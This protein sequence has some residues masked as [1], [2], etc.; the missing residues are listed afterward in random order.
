MAVENIW[1]YYLSSDRLTIDQSFG[2]TA[3]SISCILGDVLI[4]GFD[5]VAGIP[6][7][8]IYLAENQTVTVSAFSGINILQ[9]D[10]DATGGECNIIGKQ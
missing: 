1:T 10:I 4:T 8:P 6:S 9:L 2:L 7:T 3:I 5:V